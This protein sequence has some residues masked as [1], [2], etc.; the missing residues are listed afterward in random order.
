MARRYYTVARI[1]GPV[2]LLVDD[3]KQHIAVPL[4]RLP[5][6]TTDGVVLSVP[7]DHAGTAS[8]SEA[9]IDEDEARLRLGDAG[10]NNTDA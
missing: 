6:G 4:S 9:I 3:A 10:T 2:A 7:L 5:R 8:W 1:N